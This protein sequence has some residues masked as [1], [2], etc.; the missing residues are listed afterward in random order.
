MEIAPVAGDVRNV[1]QTST[2]LESLEERLAA[3]TRLR[4]RGL[5]DD[6]EYETK[7]AKLLDEI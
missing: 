6:K 3:L 7:R 1:T 2:R 4:D 5:I